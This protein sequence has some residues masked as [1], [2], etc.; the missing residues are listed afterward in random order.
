MPAVYSNACQKA[1]LAAMDDRDNNVAVKGFE[2]GPHPDHVVGHDEKHPYDLPRL[3]K[4]LLQRSEGESSRPQGLK[5]RCAA[6]IT[7]LPLQNQTRL[8]Y[9]SCPSNR[10]V[11]PLRH[12]LRPTIGVALLAGCTTSTTPVSGSRSSCLIPISCWVHLR[13]PLFWHTGV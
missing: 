12:S 5:E 6:A 9:D 7:R 10:L 1:S 8:R 4:A 11:K 2:D 13:L 3:G